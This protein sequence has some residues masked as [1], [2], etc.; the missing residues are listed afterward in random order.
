M[1]ARTTAASVKGVL[2]KD[3]D[4]AN[5]PDLTPFIDAATNLVDQV[6]AGASDKSIT[7]SSTTLELV[8][9]WLAA[10]FYAMS[11]QTLA[12][13]NTGKA[14]GRFHGQTGMF[15]TATK[16]GQSAMSIDYSGVLRAMNDGRRAGVFWLGKPVSTQTAYE[17]RD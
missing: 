7:L 14:G 17:D 15:L 3:Y 2:L 16:Y 6:S 10:H 12:Q 5:A 11:D 4:S 9:R 1:A 8:E 13:K